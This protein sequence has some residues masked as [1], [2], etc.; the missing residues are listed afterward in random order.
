MLKLKPRLRLLLGLWGFFFVFVFFILI[1]LSLHC[2]VQVLYYFQFYIY[3]I[4]I[5]IVDIYIMMCQLCIPQLAC[6]HGFTL[7]L[8]DGLT[9]WPAVILTGSLHNHVMWWVSWQPADLA[10]IPAPG[11]N[12][13]TPGFKSATS[14]IPCG[15]TLQKHC[16]TRKCFNK[17]PRK[18]AHIPHELTYQRS[19][20]PEYTICHVLNPAE[21]TILGDCMER[22]SNVGTVPVEQ[23][24]AHLPNTVNILKHDIQQRLM[25]AKNYTIK[26]RRIKNVCYWIVD[27]FIHFAFQRDFTLICLYHYTYNPHLWAY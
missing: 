24:P 6:P 20:E 4:N 18:T 23:R 19:W 8:C 7:W 27:D 9:A 13:P 21:L 10:V 16:T 5:G 26:Y 2:N 11:L 14:N 15:W 3:P 17:Y 25:L 1:S 22:D 12:R